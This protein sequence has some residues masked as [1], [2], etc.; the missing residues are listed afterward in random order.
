MQKPQSEVG[1]RGEISPGRSSW[2]S[3]SLG[4]RL[5][6]IRLDACLTSVSLQQLPYGTS[7]PSPAQAYASDRRQ[8][9]RAPGRGV[10]AG[11]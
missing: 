3:L 10:S 6:C 2:L 5:V 7:L 1:E 9:F 4:V 8:L 11:N